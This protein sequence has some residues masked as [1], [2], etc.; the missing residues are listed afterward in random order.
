MRPRNIS[1][2]KRYGTV[3]PMLSMWRGN[4]SIRNRDAIQRQLHIVFARH[5]PTHSIVLSMHH[6]Y[7]RK[8][9]HSVKSNVT[10]HFAVRSRDIQHNAGSH[11]HRHLPSVFA[12][13]IPI[14]HIRFSMHLV[15]PGKI[16]HRAKSNVI[17]HFDV[18]SRDIQHN[19]GSFI[20]R[21]LLAMPPRYDKRSRVKFL[22]KS[23][24]ACRQ[25]Q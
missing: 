22:P 7:P 21:H 15:Y 4:I 24:T 20:Q 25:A 11:V 16:C 18:R 3:Y 10:M 23:H 19:A 2:R 12:W 14:H 1:N 6:V 17:M 13:Y 8:I 9:W 5:I